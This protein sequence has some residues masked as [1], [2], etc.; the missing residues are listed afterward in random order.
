VV[1]VRLLELAQELAGVRGQGL[2]VP[3]L[4]LGKDGIESQRRLA[5]SLSRGISTVI[6]FRLCSRAPTTTI[7]SCGMKD[8]EHMD[9]A[10]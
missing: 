1:H 9:H 4:A 2:Y 6:F 10:F 3:P 8:L 7:L 5:T